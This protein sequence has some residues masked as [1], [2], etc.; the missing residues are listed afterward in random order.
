MWAT[1]EKFR[2]RARA[3]AIG[4]SLA[5]GCGAAGRRDPPSTSSWWVGALSEGHHGP[6][7]EEHQLADLSASLD[8]RVRAHHTVAQCDAVAHPDALPEHG[9]LH[10]GP[11]S[12][13]ASRPD[14]GGGPDLGA[15][16][17]RGTGADH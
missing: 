16:S 14:D 1:M 3:R 8:H 7:L 17:E 13:G 2:M 9:P 15:R 12:D 6:R 10:A 5:W 4:P 11:G